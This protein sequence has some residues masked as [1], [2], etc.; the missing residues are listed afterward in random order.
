MNFSIQSNLDNHISDPK[1]R[2]QLHEAIE[3]LSNNIYEQLHFRLRDDSRLVWDYAY[4]RV[5]N[6][7]DLFPISFLYVE[8]MITNYLYTETD[9]KEQLKQLWTKQLPLISYES[10][11]NYQMPLLRLS[12][13]RDTC[14][15]EKFKCLLEHIHRIIKESK[16]MSIDKEEANATDPNTSQFLSNCIGG[17]SASHHTDSRSCIDKDQQHCF[18][19]SHDIEE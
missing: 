13:L 3:K 19:H 12:I 8:L 17:I 16:G 11:V 2:H 4:E 18:P 10:I 15:T 9:Y 14:Q 1:K 5:F 7:K 6:G